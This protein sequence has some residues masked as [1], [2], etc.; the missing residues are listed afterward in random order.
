L[1]FD[2]HVDLVTTSDSKCRGSGSGQGSAVKAKDAAK[3]TFARDGFRGRAM[4]KK[5][6]QIVAAVGEPN[7][8]IDLPGAQTWIYQVRTHNL[9]NEVA[10][11]KCTLE[12]RDGKAA[13]VKFG[14]KE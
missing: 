9:K 12:F 8:R 2:A 6:H 13:S 4:G 1:P 10:D 3:Q 7:V 5:P 14:G 11:D